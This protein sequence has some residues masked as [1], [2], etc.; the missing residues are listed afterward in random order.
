MISGLHTPLGPVDDYFGSRTGQYSTLTILGPVVGLPIFFSLLLFFF[1][2]SPPSSFRI[3]I[4]LFPP[5]SCFFFP[6][7]LLFSFSSFSLATFLSLPVSSEETDHVVITW[8]VEVS[9][10]VISFLPFFHDRKHISINVPSSERGHNVTRKTHAV[11]GV[12]VN[13]GWQFSATRRVLRRIE[14]TRSLRAVYARYPG[15]L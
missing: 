12:V 5:L 13:K 6:S 11:S 7:F 4:F 9:R 10:V 15:K 1:F 14:L 3:R 2:F 8:P